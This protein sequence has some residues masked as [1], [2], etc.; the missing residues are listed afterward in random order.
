MQPDTVH[1]E[2]AVPELLST[3]PN[4]K[5]HFLECVCVCVYVR[6][7]ENTFYSQI[8]VVVDLLL[9]GRKDVVV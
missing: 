8:V 5:N 2:T 6:M 1:T 3:T 7:V 4:K 9:D